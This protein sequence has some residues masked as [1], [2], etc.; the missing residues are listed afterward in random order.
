M[1]EEEIGVRNKDEKKA[2][3]KARKHFLFS[4]GNEQ[5]YRQQ[6]G[7]VVSGYKLRMNKTSRTSQWRDFSRVVVLRQFSG[8]DGARDSRD[9]AHVL[10]ECSSIPGN[11]MIFVSFQMESDKTIEGSWNGRKSHG[12]P[13]QHVGPTIGPHRCMFDVQRP[14]FSK[15]SF[16]GIFNCICL[17]EFNCMEHGHS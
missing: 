16:V 13:A 6:G 11:V 15:E 5:Q 3:L 12:C 14:V 17:N 4:T 10:G 7:V 2:T 9:A 1:W 8:E